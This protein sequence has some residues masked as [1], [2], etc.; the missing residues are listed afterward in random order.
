MNPGIGTEK[1]EGLKNI[2]EARAKDGARVYFRNKDGKI[3]ILAISD[4]SNQNKVLKRLKKINYQ[5]N[6]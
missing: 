4:K 1:I 6:F 3:E 2:F 5:Y